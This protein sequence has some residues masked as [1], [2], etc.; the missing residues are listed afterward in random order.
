M[1]I[2]K[3]TLSPVNSTDGN[4]ICMDNKPDMRIVLSHTSI[5][6]MYKTHHATIAYYDI[7]SQVFSSIW[8]QH[9]AA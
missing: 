2:P 3:F 8:V 1:K 5:I 7:L 4:I 9:D 6:G